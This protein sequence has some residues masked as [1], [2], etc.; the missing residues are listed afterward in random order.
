M[1]L[2]L[3]R[4]SASCLLQFD[5]RGL[6]LNILFNVAKGK[7][8]RHVFAL[9]RNIQIVHIYF[10][11]LSLL[12]LS[13]IRTNGLT[14]DWLMSHQGSRSSSKGDPSICIC[15]SWSRFVSCKLSSFPDVNEI[16]CFL[17]ME[18]VKHRLAGLHLWILRWFNNLISGSV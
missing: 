6:H 11:A 17:F 16:W 14:L 2:G 13:A 18:F 7:L 8:V 5:Q 9:I 15:S 12:S 3:R 1:L 4:L 10:T